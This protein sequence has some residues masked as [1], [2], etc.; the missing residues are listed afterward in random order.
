MT[1][2]I[3]AKPTV[4]AI[5]VAPGSRLPMQSVEAVVAESGRGLVGDRYHGHHERHVSI[6]SASQLDAAAEI[7]GRPIDASGTR[8]N[9]TI[10]VGEIPYERGHLIN[11][12]SVQLEVF[13][14]A[15]PCRLLD[16]EIGPG[17]AKSLRRRAGSVCRVLY[18][19]TIRL[20]DLVDLDPR[21]SP[22]G[23]HQRQETTVTLENIRPAD[24]DPVTP[25]LIP[26]ALTAGRFGYDDGA[27]QEFTRDGATTYTEH[28]R[29]TEGT[30]YVDGQSF[31]SFWPP[32]Y[33]GCYD[34]TW[35]VEGGE[36]SG[37]RFIDQRSRK[38]FIGRYQ[39]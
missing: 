32:S 33:T 24:G 6:Q 27:T 11:V 14:M 30:W 20:G 5:H 1:R 8:R 37:L 18:G 26:A 23:T 39:R 35:L 28:G 36:I 10:S 31:C 16:D 38:Q 7:L 12:G 19:G 22:V 2:T 15:A 34:I 3:E 13:R 9:I 29:M 25:E 17:A 4:L 21:P